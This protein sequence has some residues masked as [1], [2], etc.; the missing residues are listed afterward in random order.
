MKSDE[1]IQK[2]TVVF[3]QRVEEINTEENPFLLQADPLI[4]HVDN[5]VSNIRER[6]P[7]KENEN[8]EAYNDRCSRRSTKLH[9]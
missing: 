9:V 7:I 5:S 4:S 6:S 2:Q 8:A 1:E 3:Q